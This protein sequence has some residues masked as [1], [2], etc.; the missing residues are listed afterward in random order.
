MQSYHDGAGVL[1]RE[2]FTGAKDADLHQAM[3]ERR[4]QLEREGA[5]GFHRTRIGRNTTCPC[6]SG[7][8]FKK[9]C[10]S[11]AALVGPA[12]SR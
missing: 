4:A 2:F 1:H 9:C 6:G 3:D 8:K 7:R 12:R 10:I 5:T 11:G